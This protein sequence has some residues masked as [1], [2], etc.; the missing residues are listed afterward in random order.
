MTWTPRQAQAFIRLN[1]R[2]TGRE[3]AVKLGCSLSTVQHMRVKEKKLKG[4]GVRSPERLARLVL[5]PQHVV[6]RGSLE[7]IE[8]HSRRTAVEVRRHLRRGRVTGRPHLV[9][10]HKRNIAWT[11]AEASP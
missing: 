5:V 1:R 3:L 9:D 7:E 11:S 2:L 6:L 10:E 8:A 4:L